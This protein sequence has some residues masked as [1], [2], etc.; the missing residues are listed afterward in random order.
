MLSFLSPSVFTA[1][2]DHHIYLLPHSLFVDYRHNL[3]CQLDVWGVI[4]TVRTGQIYSDD[5]LCPLDLKL[6]TPIAIAWDGDPMDCVYR[7]LTD[8]GSEFVVIMLNYDHTSELK[9]M[10]SVPQ[11]EADYCWGSS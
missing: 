7:I 2:D 9:E 4:M 5:Y 3:R 10:R 8:D 1:F 11:L 6:K